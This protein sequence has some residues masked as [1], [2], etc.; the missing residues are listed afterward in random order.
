MNFLIALKTNYFGKISELNRQKSF[1]QNSQKLKKYQ[2]LEF[3]KLLEISS[4]KEEICPTI[5]DNPCVKN[6]EICKLY[7]SILD[8]FNKCFLTR[9]QINPKSN[10]K[11]FAECYKKIIKLLRI[12]L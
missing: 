8:I 11:A 2:K 12:F 3:L 6:E 10:F 5:T 1:S 9:D 7:Q 4:I